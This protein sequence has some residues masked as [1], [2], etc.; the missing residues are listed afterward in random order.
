MTMGTDETYE[1]ECITHWHTKAISV[2]Y[3]NIFQTTLAAGRESGQQV[4]K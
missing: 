3:Q 2:A 1:A 4:E